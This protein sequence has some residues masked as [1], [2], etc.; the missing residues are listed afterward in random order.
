MDVTILYAGK[1]RMDRKAT[2]PGKSVS[3]HVA[4]VLLIL[5]SVV[6]TIIIY[7]Y[8]EGIL[9]TEQE[10]SSADRAKMILRIDEGESNIAWGAQLNITNPH[11]TPLS[12][13]QVRVELTPLNFANWSLFN[14]T[15]VYFTRDAG[16]EEPL[17]YWVEEY[18]PDA[19]RAVL[20]V[21]LPSL[22]AGPGANETIYMWL[23]PTNPYPSYNDPERVFEFFDDFD[24]VLDPLV[25]N[26][27]YLTNFSLSDS[28]LRI[29]QGGLVM[30]SPLPFRLQDGYAA[31]ARF[32]HPDNVGHYGGTVPE[33]SSS[34]S[35][36][37][38]NA[39]SDATVLYMRQIS[40][41]WLTYWVADGSTASYN[42]GT[43]IVTNT[44]NNRWY[45][46]GIGVNNTSVA[47]WLD[48]PSSPLLQ[49]GGITWAKDM[50]YIV[51]GAF[52]AADGGSTLDI[53][54]T[55]YDWVR[56]RKWVYPEPTVSLTGEWTQVTV[57][58][59]YIRN[60][61]TG[62]VTL[63]TVYVYD[64]KDNTL[65]AQVDLPPL[66]VP[67]NNVVKVS[68]NFAGTHSGSI[69]LVVKSQEGASARFQA[70]PQ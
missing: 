32:L 63:D 11:P 18:D 8:Y 20:W 62:K 57:V 27:I 10:G 13:Y 58:E 69:Q 29:N 34:P 12:E 1:R 65:I 49:I 2:A 36:R 38:S 25:W 30:Q 68:L 41:T 67:P 59:L 31:E 66:Q 3:M 43:G 51:L 24:N 9:P 14:P 48:N 17:Y 52:N 46:G 61:G 45:L 23:S 5:L 33:V 39:D 42:V 19:P 55:L 21:R 4:T 54:D 56:I 37:G 22:P 60:M 70:K 15:S 44:D 35:T 7:I 53:Q 64:L 6:S 16:G 50:R 40:S 28:I 47:I 26:T